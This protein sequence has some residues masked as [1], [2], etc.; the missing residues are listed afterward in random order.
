MFPG[1]KAKLMSI[2]TMGIGSA[3][4]TCIFSAKIITYVLRI[5]KKVTKLSTR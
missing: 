4:L 1:Y 2:I 3:I 5:N